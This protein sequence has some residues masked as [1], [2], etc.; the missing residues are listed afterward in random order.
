MTGL[1]LAAVG[2]AYLRQTDWVMSLVRW[3]GGLF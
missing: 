3:I 1:F 2:I